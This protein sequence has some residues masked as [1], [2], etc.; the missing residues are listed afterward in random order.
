MTNELKDILREI[1]RYDSISNSWLQDRYNNLSKEVFVKSYIKN[2]ILIRLHKKN[3]NP[4]DETSFEDVFCYDTSKQKR[5]VAHYFS[6]IQD[7]KGINIDDLP[8][9][10]D[11]VNYQY[12]FDFNMY[13]HFLNDYCK[14]GRY[15]EPKRYIVYTHFNINNLDIFN[16]IK[17][18]KNFDD[19]DFAKITG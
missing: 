1:L 16:I 8:I 13:Y 3:S 12:S 15:V 7:L 2:A 5:A 19:E 9:E 14:N 6:R 10:D 4:Y 17:F 18:I 11:R